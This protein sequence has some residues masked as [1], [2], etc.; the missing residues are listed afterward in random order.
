MK[1]MYSMK[2]RK[3]VEKMKQK[4]ENLESPGKTWRRDR[5]GSHTYSG[6][7]TNFFKHHPYTTSVNKTQRFQLFRFRWGSPGLGSVV[8]VSRFR[9]YLSR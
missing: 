8:P 1:K 7:L 3:E 9:I 5:S 4:L 6:A 2:I